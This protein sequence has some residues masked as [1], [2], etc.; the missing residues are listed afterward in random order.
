[1]SSTKD[2]LREL[3]TQIR[4]ERK[5]GANTAQR[6]GSFLL[7]L[8]EAGVDIEELARYFIRKDQE[9]STDFLL[10]MFSGALFGH[11]S[12]GPFGAGACLKIDSATGKSYF[13]V[14]E[15]Y[16]RLKAYFDALG[17]RHLSHIG[18]QF[19]LSPAKMECIGVVYSNA[20]YEVLTDSAGSLLTDSEGSQL[21]AIMDVSIPEGVYRCYFKATDG[22]KTIINEFVVDDFA[23]CREF[24]IKP[25]VHENVSNQYYWR[26]VVSI[27]EDYIDLS[28]SDC[29]TGSMIPK[30]GDTIVT[31]GNKTD[32]SRQN[33]ILLSTV[34]DDAPCIKQYAGI[35][36]Y[37]MVGKE[38]TV[39][40]PKGNKITGQFVVQGGSSGFGNFADITFPDLE[41]I[42]TDIQEA[43]E[44]AD[45]AQDKANKAQ[46]SVTNLHGY[47]DG[48][49]ADGIITKAEAKA[50]EKYINI[51]KSTKSDVESTYNKLYLNE[52]L[53]GTPKTNL[54]NAKVSLFGAIENLLLS[55]D[56]AIKDEKTT[57]E[58]KQDVDS[59]Y[60]AFNAAYAA[61]SI[62][63]E[64]ANKAIQ[65]KLK[66]YADSAQKSA[67]GLK[68]SIDNIP[69][70]IKDTV[71]QNLGYTDFA[72][73][74]ELALNGKTIIKGGFINAELIEATTIIT[75]QL[76]A[77]AIATNSLNVNNKFMIAKD[78]TFKGVGGELQ[79]MLMTGAY[80]SPFRSGTFT[81]QNLP[82]TVP[83][84]QDNN[85]VIVPGDT[86]L[87]VTY[88]KL[89]SGM[90]YD[91]F[92]ATIL[93]E[94]FNGVMAVGNL[95]CYS[96]APIYENGE[97]VE[98]LIVA[99]QEG[100]DIQGFS[101]GTSFRGW[102]VKNRFKTTPVPT[103]YITITTSVS[104]EGS[105]I[106]KGGGKKPY[107][108]EG[109]LIAEAN[110]GYVFK[111][112]NGS[113]SDTNPTH[114]AYWLQDQNFTAYFE[115]E[116]ITYT[117]TLG[118]SPLGSGI[119]SG[120]GTKTKGTKGVIKAEAAPGY[121]FSRWSDGSVLAETTITWDEDKTLTAYFITYTPST[122]ELLTNA[123]LDNMTGIE[124]MDIGMVGED[125]LTAFLNQIIWNNKSYTSG[126]RR[127]ISFN[128]GYLS[129]KIYA[130][131]KYRLSVT[132]KGAAVDSYLIIA[133]GDVSTFSEG[134]LENFNDVGGDCVRLETF[135]GENQSI[136]MDFTPSRGT[137]ALDAIIFATEAPG[138]NVYIKAISLKEI[139]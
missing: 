135:T 129:G 63:I 62:A 19:I 23:Q 58:E 91:G 74:Q 49:F 122:E 17:I 131:K 101:D 121:A 98:E 16:V 1:M 82:I 92:N 40:S 28:M 102:I 88:C 126:S 125:G 90:Q 5:I 109:V 86:N 104:P 30:A 79:D 25:G 57:V 34:G 112:W 93:N 123:N 15:I 9:D 117:V 139:Q 32:A 13:E 21:E 61:M 138:K 130:G 80:R 35:N 33:V 54:L 103:R 72:A 81:W 50:I 20:G 37:S 39:L 67:D 44:A 7:S 45:V 3:A 78:G 119:V 60:E 134:T 124:K 18:G 89:P 55:I 53:T 75:A 87:T 11:F 26:R 113:S 105:G 137:T 10:T 69:K 110:P 94:Y 120:G 128:K 27:G 70:E 56:T 77:D 127:A 100:I 29:D 95:A 65:D 85:N 24:N 4:D 12:D 84:L 8:V 43:R 52:Y 99:P 107:G 59:K 83:G 51:V 42:K 14:D 6:V 108:T 47:V 132:F 136:V 66:S 41:D 48:A 22:S 96:N 118:V 38:T 111:C 73:L 68:T 36:S 133:I 76:I 31:V 114:N 46:S 106:V 97:A 2:I 115:K 116:I 71:A 64:V